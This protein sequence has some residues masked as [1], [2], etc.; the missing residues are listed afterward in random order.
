M[1]FL[2]LLINISNLTF[3]R[4]K[5]IISDTS[6]PKLYEKSGTWYY[7]KFHSIEQF[8]KSVDFLKMKL[9][10]FKPISDL[11]FSV[12]LLPKKAKLLHEKLNL[13]I[14]KIPAREKAPLNIIGQN[15][16]HSN[17]YIVMH[18]SNCKLPGKVIIQNSFISTVSF[19][20]NENASLLLSRTKCVRTFEPIISSLHFHTRFNRYMTETHYIDVFDP[21]N[22]QTIDDLKFINQNITG[23]GQC[24]LMADSGVDPSSPWLYDSKTPSIKGEN[25][26]HR[27]IKH[28]YSYS[29][30]YKDDE[31]GHG[32]FLAGLMVGSTDCSKEA[33]KY[34]GIAPGGK[35]VVADIGRDR[36]SF[37]PKNFSDLTRK[38][39]QQ[40]CA[41]QLNAWTVE[42]QPLL[43]LLMDQIAFDH[44]NVLT[45]FP[46]EGD[47]Y[48]FI[49]TPSDAK[50]VL[51]VGG[52]YSK[53]T[54]K[55]FHEKN[56]GV[57]IYPTGM[58]RAIAG[59]CDEHGKILFNTTNTN[60]QKIVIDEEK[61]QACVM[62]DETEEGLE[63]CRVL[64]YFES[65]PL[66]KYFNVPVIRLP[67]RWKQPFKTDLELSIVPADIDS[68]RKDERFEIIPES[69]T[70]T[71]FPGRIKPEIVAPAGPIVSSKSYA[72]HNDCSISSLTGK[73]GTSIAAAFVS[74]DVML[75]SQYFQEKQK[76]KLS[77][78]LAKALLIASANDPLSEYSNYEGNIV[79][80]T[81]D[82]RSRVGSPGYGYGMPA[83]QRCIDN[84]GYFQK[85]VKIKPH[86]TY[87][88][89]FTMKQTG[90]VDITISWLDM[91]RDPYSTIQLSSPLVAY[92]MENS[93]WESVNILGNNN[94]NDGEY[95]DTYN[96]NL[97]ISF[98]GYEGR[99]YQLLIIADNFD[100]VPSVDFS[101][102][103]LGKVQYDGNNC[104]LRKKELCP[105]KCHDS[106]T[107]NKFRCTCYGEKSGDFCQYTINSAFFDKPTTI[108]NPKSHYWYYY[109]LS[110]PLS[111]GRGSKL[112]FDMKDFDERNF[113]FFIQAQEVPSHQRYFCSYET[114]EWGIIDHEKHT[115]TLQ[116]ESW[117]FMKARDPLFIGIFS[118]SQ[119]AN[120]CTFIPSVYSANDEI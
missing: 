58:P 69:G 109:S 33:M 73:T 5:I 31:D 65:K 40:K 1:L 77:A 120:N 56:A 115:L 59:I 103:V 113:E 86:R 53:M 66:T 76:T 101:F 41:V 82:R 95:V 14:K 88:S 105:R 43:T 52:V 26:E 39:E 89:C 23:R 84:L 102:V 12:Y 67:Q 48:G 20:H 71:K 108:K 19:Q 17:E 62:N 30:D 29:N 100:G 51:T 80:H 60:Y 107:C 68:G 42:N 50:N 6:T 64:L 74:A 34:N 22:P 47:E 116:Y 28:Y 3:L 36:E 93:Y 2:I 87:V 27:K 104:E 49:H 75:L 24:V 117:D 55:A 25:V 114:C 70:R 90:P 35:V 61:T 37:L 78:T 46:A 99:R 7:I 8:E 16:T 10:D 118:K 9:S 110:L 79:I 18:S 98:T 44:P 96:T 111:W 97:K 83:I 11:Y 45:V 85:N 94:L 92:I 21:L 32:T 63:K 57:Y 91:P 15:N 119:Y 112:V 106:G 4:N 81:K 72:D 13:W 38:A 54:S